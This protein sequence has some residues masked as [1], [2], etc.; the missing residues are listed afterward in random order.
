[1]EARIFDHVF[2]NTKYP[3]INIPDGLENDIPPGVKWN[4][5]VMVAAQYILLAG[6]VIDEEFIQKDGRSSQGL[7]RWKLWE[8][9]LK[10]LSGKEL[11]PEVR[12]AVIE[13]RKKLVSLHPEL[14]PISQGGSRP[15]HLLR[16][17]HM[18]V[19]PRIWPQDR[20]FM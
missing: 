13:A 9:K 11:A 18:P 2:D 1:M 10:E 20:E 17:K 4:S 15:D 6:H 16:W 19:A 3:G 8:G 7:D 5:R 14:F 12:A